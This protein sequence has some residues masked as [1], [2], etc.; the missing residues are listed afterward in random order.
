MDD[1]IVWHYA[2]AVEP[3]IRGKAQARKFLNRF[4]GGI[5]EVRWRI[6][7]WAERGDRLFVEGVDEYVTTEGR[8]VAA[9]YAGVID[10]KGDLVVGW[11]DYVDVGV[12][13]AQIAGG[14]VSA[15]VRGADRPRGGGLTMA[16]AQILAINAVVL[17]V[18]FLVLWRVAVAIKD[19]TFI[20][21][22]WPTGMVVMAISTFVQTGSATPRRLL[23]LGLCAAWG[24][25]LGGYL[26]W[27]WRKQGPDRRYIR[28]MEKAERDKGWSFAKTALLSVFA[29]QAP[30]LFVVCL[31]VQL[32]QIDVDP[33]SIGPVAWVGVALAVIGLAFESTADFQLTRFRADPA[34]R[35]KV[36]SSGLWR[37]TRHPNYFGDSCVWWGLYLIAAETHLGVWAL[38]GPILLTWTLMKWSGAPTVEYRMRKTRPDY[39]RYIETTSGFVPMPPRR[40]PAHEAAP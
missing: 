36:L 33:A 40:A 5:A 23:L 32:G 30:M 37:Y 31:P 26:L 24:V 18:L 14:P 16:V 20:D 35:G 25:R 13:A 6:F 28:M 19:V 27:R 17:V 2:A 34:T 8:T 1:D 15:Q 3:P 38:P 4:G 7:D 10:F 9:A 39:V 12:M 11:R 21:S 29:T 22:V